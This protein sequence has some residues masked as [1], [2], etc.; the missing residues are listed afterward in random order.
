MTTVKLIEYAE[1][2][3]EVRAEMIAWLERATR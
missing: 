3:P 1:A 2:P